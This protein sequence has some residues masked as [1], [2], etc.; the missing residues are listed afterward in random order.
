MSSRRIVVQQNIRKSGRSGFFSSFFANRRFGGRGPKKVKTYL[1][2]A[3]WAG[4][5]LL[6]A[7]SVSAVGMYAWLANELPDPDAIGT[8]SVAQTTRIYDRTGE[9]ILYEVHGAQKRTV[10][11]LEDVS[12]HVISATISAEDKHFYEHK[13][14]SITGYLRAFYKN[15]RAGERT[16][17]GSTIT[18]QFVKNAVLTPEKTYTRKAKE[19]V[20]SYEIER[21]F[22]KQEILKMYLNEIPYGPVIYGIQSAAESF[23]GKDARDL[24][25]SEAAMITAVSNATTYYSPYGNNTDKLI[26]RTHWIIDQMVATESISP[27]EAEEAKQDDLL[28]RIQ[29]QK[30]RIIAPH[31]VFYVREQLA[32]EYGEDV[33][34][35]GG[36]KVITSIDLEKQRIAEEAIKEHL[37]VITRWGGNTAGLVAIDAKNGDILTMVGSADYFDESINGNYNAMVGRLQPGSSIKPIVYAAAFEKGL[38][39][40]TVLYDVETDF[41]DGPNPYRPRNYSLNENGPV[42]IRQALAGSLNI[43]AVKALYIAGLKYFSDFSSRF[44]Y[45][46]L[47]DTSRFGLSLVLGGA[48][49]VPLEHINAFSVLAQDGVYRDPRA[50]LKVEDISGKVLFE[51]EK[52]VSGKQAVDKEIAR[53]INDILTDNTARA[54]VFGESNYLTLGA[55]PVGA[56]TGTTN[57]NKD[58]WAVGYT[59]SLVSGVWVGNAS[60]AFMKAGADGSIVAAP[61]WNV[62]MR[63]ALEGSPV[64]TFPS[65]LPVV[66][67]KPIL[68][69]ERNAQMKVRIDTVSGKLATEYTPEEYVEERGFGVPHSI[70]FFVDPSDP[71]GP[72]PEHPE[73]DPQFA[74]WERAVA[75]WVAKQ[76]LEIS[77]DVP[78]TEYDD[79]HVPENIPSISFVSPR[80]AQVI[81]DRALSVQLNATAR[82]GI[83]KV[84]FSL[85][86]EQFAERA[87]PLTSPV[88]I[89]NRFPRGFHTFTAT[90]LDDVGNRASTSVTINLNA[91][92]GPLGVEWETPV[93]YSSI[94]VSGFPLTVRFRIDDI[95]SIRRIR[96]FAREEGF[97]EKEYAIGTIESPSL[98]RMSLEWRTLPDTVGNHTIIVRAE[99]RNGDIKEEEISVQVLR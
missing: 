99:L 67:G 92:A 45:T 35:R 57:S 26:E 91:E 47:S 95:A 17:G 6:L 2:Y 32:K 86:G 97:Q 34:D 73:N 56:K 24:T 19:L 61:I 15:F 25:I 82:R 8:R 22:S 53:Q 71:R 76:G 33:L 7:G 49:V 93:P 29:P 44:G 96:V 63:K 1:S 88:S 16:E 70:L 14:F 77:T 36:L 62:F 23:F 18:Q 11:E 79:I 13:G 12:P 5:A 46:T 84:R 37:P 59:P 80:D 94:Y 58:A 31:F 50:I 55:R 64:E 54:W 69:G 83:A 52:S 72:V 41:S 39:P 65:A 90:V 40:D 68:D 87:W 38:A 28:A 75:D 30:A 27:E 42:T 21:R 78:P 4:I 60:G 81:M 98:P 85:D 51:A 9:T 20:F 66:T 74:R 48:E 89:P 43:P 3:F 10:V